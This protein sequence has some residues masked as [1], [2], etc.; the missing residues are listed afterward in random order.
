MPHSTH[1]PKSHH[2]AAPKKGGCGCDGGDS[3]A[4][5]VLVVLVIVI[6]VVALWTN[7]RPRRQGFDMARVMD[8]AERGAKDSPPLGGR[9]E[10]MLPSEVSSD[11][12]TLDGGPQR[13]SVHAAVSRLYSTADVDPLVTGQLYGHA[14]DVRPVYAQ[15][16]SHGDV[17][18]LTEYSSS[19][20][21]GD[22]GVDVG[23]WGLEEY[24]GKQIGFDDG[25]PATWALPST[26]VRWYRPKQRD[27]YGPESPTVYSE[28]LFSLFEPDHDPLVN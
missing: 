28:G 25:I 27:F 15:R 8:E 2:G 22:L 4:T 7:R 6:I 20:G 26:P 9:R 21:P 23:P 17:H 10:G 16:T 13:R 5:A 18:G 1:H 3:S 24:G 11:A 19:G 14:D 12:L